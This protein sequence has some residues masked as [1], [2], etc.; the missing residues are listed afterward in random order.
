MKEQTM[1]KPTKTVT[2]RV[3]AQL[4]VFVVALPLLPLLISRRWDWWEAWTFAAISIFGFAVS[5][6]LAARRN[7][8]L[9]TERARFM[10]QDDVK[11]WDRVLAPLVGLGGGVILLVAGLDALNGWPPDFPPAVKIIALVVILAGYSLGAY[12]LVENRFFSGTVR[13]QIDRGHQ[14]ISSGPYRWMRHPGYAGAFWTYLALPLFLDSLWAF[15]PAFLLLA[16]LVV[17][18]SLE[19]RTLQAELPGYRAYARRVPYRLFPGVW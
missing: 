11:A 9:I 3:V 19:D 10:R 14:V 12:A 6:G 17:R 5:R 7:P 1:S 15:L 16:A 8:D 4:L 2:P 13:L 18:T